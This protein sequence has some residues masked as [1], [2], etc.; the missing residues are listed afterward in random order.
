M[1]TLLQECAS[2]LTIHQSQSASN[3]ILVLM[4]VMPTRSLTWPTNAWMHKAKINASKA[5]SVNGMGT[6]LTAQRQTLLWMLVCALLLLHQLQHLQQIQLPCHSGTPKDATGLA[7]LR[8]LLPQ[9][10][11][12]TTLL[13]PLIWRESVSVLNKL[14]KIPVMESNASGTNQHSQERIQAL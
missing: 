12:L 10:L 14:L 4:K 6:S 5:C 13:I 8:H 11:V 1:V 3:Q 9:R 2:L 7:Q